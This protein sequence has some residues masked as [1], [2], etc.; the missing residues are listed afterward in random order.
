M[1]AK[2]NHEQLFAFQFGNCHGVLVTTMREERVTWKSVEKPDIHVLK[3][4]KVRIRISR[5]Q[6]KPPRNQRQFLIK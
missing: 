4:G 5:Q 1:K 3:W 2:K 6:T